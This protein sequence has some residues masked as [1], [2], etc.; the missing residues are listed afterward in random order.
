MPK[1]GRSKYGA[2]KT[3]VDGITFDSKAEAARYVILKQMEKAGLI[4]RLL[5]QH[6]IGLFVATKTAGADLIKIGVYIADFAYCT[7]ATPNKCAGALGVVEDVKG[8]KT[9]LYRWKKKHVEA[10]YGIQIIEIR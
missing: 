4:H 6:R 9:A 3:T 8:M 2:V 5:L 10:Q 1:A 7:C